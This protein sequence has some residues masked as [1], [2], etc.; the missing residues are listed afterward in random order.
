M[1]EDGRDGI[2]ECD[3]RTVSVLTTSPNIDDGSGGK[4]DLMGVVLFRFATS[5]SLPLLSS[6]GCFFDEE[7]PTEVTSIRALLSPLL[8][9]LLP[10]DNLFRHR[11]RRRRRRVRSPPAAT[12]DEFSI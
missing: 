10:T 7:D 9:L 11:H 2:A 4:A 3:G 12:S 6:L 8:L 1:N 5:P